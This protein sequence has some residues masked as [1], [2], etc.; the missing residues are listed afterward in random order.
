MKPLSR[1]ILLFVVSVFA[2][3][4]PLDNFTEVEEVAF[5]ATYAV[6]LVDSR[7]S[8]GD[9]LGDVAEGV[10]LSVDPDG[11]LRFRYAGEIAAVGSEVVFERL[12]AIAQG[13]FVPIVRSRQ[14]A[15]FAGGDDLDIDRVDI[16]SGRLV[17]NLTNDYDRPVTVNL[18]IPD[19][20][21]DGE[22]FSVGGE[23]PAYS[24]EG[25]LPTIANQDDPIDLTDYVLTI[26]DDSL[27]FEYDVIDEAGNLLEPS[28]QTVVAITNLRFSSV[29]GYLGSEEYPGGRDTVEVDF[30]DNY[31]EGE[32][33][34]VDPKIRMT[35][36][37][38]FGVP[39]LALVDVLNVIDV[40]GN[41]IPITGEAVEQGFRFNSPTVPG[42]TAFTTFLFDNTN[43]N[44]AEVLS[45]RPV[46]L[47]YEINALINPDE[48]PSIRGFLTDG[49]SYRARVEVELP[50]YGNARGFTVRDTFPVDLMDRFG[51]VTAVDFRLT[52]RNGLPVGV[53][54]TGTFVDADGNALADLTDGAFTLLRA[55]PV[56]A[57]GDVTAETTPVTQDIRVADDRLEA[58]RSA[59]R[60]ILTLDIA[61][62]DDG[63]PFVRVTDRQQLEVLLG[64]RVEVRQP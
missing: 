38:T 15:P 20:T 36:A 50:L 1:A 39:A 16:K 60:L 2:A 62:T 21:R 52:T 23:L 45:A 63:T 29:E 55:A 59:N 35:L 26:S 61:T 25:P 57:N 47:D 51:D 18:R 4:S 56:D 7:V 22:T 31:L 37:N 14:A 42:D 44:I 30:F 5:D 28:A 13:V 8:L 6:P 19:A 54:L 43:S 17:Y 64:A 53:E 34:F 10:T 46:A 11:L 40:N 58:I 12:E 41:V 24:G 33:F 32:I 9:L 49:A 3:C 48:D 27:Y